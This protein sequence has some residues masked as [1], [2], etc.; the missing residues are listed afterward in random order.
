MELLLTVLIWLWQ[1]GWVLLL[2][3]GLCA[4]ALWLI[5]PLRKK[6]MLTFAACAAA[7]CVLLV[8]LCARPVVLYDGSAEETEQIR[9]LAAGPYSNREPLVPVCAVVREAESGMTVQVWYAF[10]G[11]MTYA[12][13]GEGLPSIVD[14]LFPWQ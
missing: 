3:G 6:K 13:D 9:Q 5:W 10:V 1:I 2:G 11:S 4:L 14:W 8:T 12:I 7:V